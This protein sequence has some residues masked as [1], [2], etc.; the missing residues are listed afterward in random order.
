MRKVKAEVIMHLLEHIGHE[1]R[2]RFLDTAIDGSN[3][4]CMNELC[5][6]A[7][8]L[9]CTECTRLSCKMSTIWEHRR[10]GCLFSAI[11]FSEEIA[12]LKNQCKLTHLII[13]IMVI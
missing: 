2:C 7:R 1:V 6:R 12:A 9:I 11:R 10:E 4:S 3:P 5:P 13:I 8:H